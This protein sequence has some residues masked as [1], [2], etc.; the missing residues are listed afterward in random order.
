MAEWCQTTPQ[1]G[2]WHPVLYD[3]NPSARGVPDTVN[4]D[5]Q[6]QAPNLSWRELVATRGARLLSARPGTFDDQERV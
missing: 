2:V 4:A 5:Q 3:L 6:C 1:I